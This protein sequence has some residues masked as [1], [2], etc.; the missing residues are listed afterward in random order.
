VTRR[1]SIIRE[2]E[3]AP[4][5]GPDHDLTISKATGAPAIGPIDDHELTADPTGAAVEDVA[6]DCRAPSHVS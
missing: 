1:H 2:H 6:V 4:R 3:T 5:V